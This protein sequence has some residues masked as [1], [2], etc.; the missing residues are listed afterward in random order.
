MPPVFDQGRLGSCTAN[1]LAALYCAEARIIDCPS[2]LA[3]YWAERDLEGCVDWDSGAVIRDG[4]KV[5]A[6]V[7]CPPETVWEYDDRDP[8][9][10]LMRPGDDVWSAGLIHRLAS[11]HRIMAVD[12]L[13][14]EIAEGH[15]VVFGFSVP[16]SMKY[17]TIHL[18]YPAPTE[19]VLGG[20]AVVAVGYDDGPAEVLVRNSWGTEAGDGGHFWM[21]YAMWDDPGWLGDAWAARV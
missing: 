20:H 6:G 8:G 21:S 9:R 15:P 17:D 13:R 5:M 1:A 18:R 10:Y 3:I 11:Y 19:R 16:E 12:E 7:G 2:R 14:R 4:L